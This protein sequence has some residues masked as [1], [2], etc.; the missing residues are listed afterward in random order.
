MGP[1][2]YCGA[3]APFGF[4]PRLARLRSKG[5]TKWACAGHRAGLPTKGQGGHEMDELVS[6][7]DDEQADLAVAA[8]ALARHWIT[9]G[10]GPIELAGDQLPVPTQDGVRLRRIGHILE[11]V[12][13]KA[14]TDF[15]KPGP[16]SV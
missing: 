16:L 14:M 8:D 7:E 15:G 4:D 13:T 11:G 10:L 1:C 9:A 6:F 5:S 12:A 2:A 3:A